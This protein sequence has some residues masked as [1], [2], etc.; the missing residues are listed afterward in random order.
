MD[1]CKALGLS[2]CKTTYQTVCTILKQA[3]IENYINEAFELI[4]HFLGITKNDILLSKPLVQDKKHDL[5]LAMT[6]KRA[7]GYPLQYII[8]KWEFYG[9]PIYVGEGVLIPRSDTEV[10][11]DSALEYAKEKN[12][13]PLKIVDLCSGSGCI[14]IALKK[15]LPICDIYAIEKSEQALSFLRKNV[16][17]NQVDV[18]II[19]DDVLNPQTN[20]ADFDIIVSNPPYLTKTDMEQ[21]QLEV[22]YEPE[23][24]LY[25]TEDGLHFYRE[26]T[27]IWT[28]KLKKGGFL[29]FEIGQNQHNDVTKIL[30]QNGYNSICNKRDLCDIIRVVCGKVERCSTS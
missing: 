3:E 25:G 8:G 29:S 13:Q 21:L 16:E 7:G 4:Y 22:S 6:H 27:K 18:H 14:A 20:I 19:K 24:A 2:D 15:M 10:L 17:L 9:L 26:I 23:M 5:L 30:F 1:N 12:N 28:N 11:V